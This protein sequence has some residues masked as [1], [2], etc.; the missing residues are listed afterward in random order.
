M[1]KKEEKEEK[2]Y[3]GSDLLEETKK[4]LED[5]DIAGKLT[6]DQREALSKLLVKT[7]LKGDL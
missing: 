3:T 6:P 2:T 5:D 1:V 7:A 4:I